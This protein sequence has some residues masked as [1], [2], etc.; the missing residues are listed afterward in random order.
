MRPP[1][2]ER[3]AA[4]LDSAGAATLALGLA[5]TAGWLVDVRILRHLVEGA[6]AAKPIASVRIGLLG[7]GLL[8]HES[9]PRL[10]AVLVV[11]KQV[12][13]NLLAIVARIVAA[14]GGRVWAESEPGQGAR[15][16][17]IIDPREA[18]A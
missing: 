16:F 2:P 1:A 11:L 15:F 6:P 5:G 17:F 13:L 18:A 9:R 7:A 8:R 4:L 12:F 3:A 14:H 10:S